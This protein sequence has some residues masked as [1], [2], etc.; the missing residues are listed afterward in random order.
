M[1]TRLDDEQLSIG[2]LT[3]SNLVATDGLNISPLAISTYDETTSSYVGAPS[4]KWASGFDNS[5]PYGR[6]VLDGRYVEDHSV[7]EFEFIA[8]SSATGM[9]YTIMESEGFIAFETSGNEFKA[10]AF[11]SGTSTSFGLNSVTFEN[12]GKYKFRYVVEG[13]KRSY[14]IM[15]MDE[16][17]TPTWFH[18][19][20]ITETAS[21]NSAK[22]Q[23]LWLGRHQVINRSL[24]DGKINLGSL[25][26]WIKNELVF[27]GST[28]VDGED[29]FSTYGLTWFGW[30]ASPTYKVTAPGLAKTSLA[31]LDSDGEARFAAKQDKLEAGENIQLTD[32]SVDHMDVSGFSGTSY[33]TVP[34]DSFWGARTTATN[35]ELGMRI[36]TPA[37][38]STVNFLLGPTVG[39]YSLGFATEMNASGNN[40]RIRFGLSSNGSTWDIGFFGPTTYTV[41]PETWYWVKYSY[42]SSGTISGA[43]AS[44][45][46]KIELST[47][48]KTWTEYYATSQSATPYLSTSATVQIG[49]TSSSMYQAYSGTIDLKACYTSVNGTVVWNG[50][51]AVAGTDYTVV[52]TPTQEAYTEEFAEISAQLSSNVWTPDNLV[53]GTNISITQVEKPV[54]D[55]NTVELLHFNDDAIDSISN[56][57]LTSQIPTYSIGKFGK[58]A[59]NPTNFTIAFNTPVSFT[60]GNSYYT[61]DCWISSN[62]SGDYNRKLKLLSSYSLDCI[63][64][65]TN[66]VEIYRAFNNGSQDITVNYPNDITLEV[67]VWHHFALVGNGTQTLMFFDGKLF[68]STSYTAGNESIAFYGFTGRMDVDELRVSNVARWTSDFTPFSQP[69]APAGGAIQYQ[70]NNTQDISGLIPLTQKAAAG[71]VASLD[72]NALIPT[73]QLPTIDGGNANA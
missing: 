21:I 67:G 17:D 5:N 69:Y 52:G 15:R 8:P 28:A 50:A 35:W 14:Y 41:A 33:I 68:Y 51:T 55:S 37:I 3:S 18:L 58:A 7:Y 13:T 26:I 72:S 40:W 53:A 19:G 30:D 16:S 11:G 45:V 73:T 9:Q 64:F 59:Q 32:K 70:I 38:S 54:I 62:A 24:G 57:A 56:E 4:A 49:N 6:I 44:N 65:G 60:K 66:S 22:T 2:A 10:Y 61:I 1:V 36:K 46:Y 12:N 43:S 63:N 71:G 25:K 47:D 39:F 29:G 48:G 27:D 34:A 42:A 20:D 31:N 23:G